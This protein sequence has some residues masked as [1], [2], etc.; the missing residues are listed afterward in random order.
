MEIKIEKGFCDLTSNEQ[1]ET[2]GGFWPIIA[3]GLAIFGG[4]ATLRQ[5]VAEEAKAAAY[6]DGYGR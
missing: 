3:G 1:E 5:M 2:N 6:R 4:Y